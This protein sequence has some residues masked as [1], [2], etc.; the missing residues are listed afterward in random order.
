MTTLPACSKLT[1]ILPSIT[2]CT[3][4]RPQ[5][6]RSR[7]AH[8][9]AWLE[10]FVHRRPVRRRRGG[11]DMSA[12]PDLSALVSARLC[13]D[14][15]SPMGAIGN[16]LELL[17]LSARR[18]P[19]PSSRSSTRA[20][21]P[22]SPSCA[23]TASPSGRPTR[24]RASRSTRRRRSPTRCSTAASPSPGTARGG[25]LPRTLTRARLSRASSASRRACRWAATSASSSPASA[26]TPRG[27]R[28][29]H[30]AA[31]RA[32]GACHATGR[33]SPS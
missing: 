31:G 25:D 26:I 30:R 21:R 20:S 17:Q 2:D 3:C 6:G 4:P 12:T 19:R 28:P 23:S 9:H 16:G 8:Q 33:R 5:S 10:E 22:R 27:R 29:A 13:H 14:L 32:L 11:R 18:R 24:R 7:M 15:I 1:V